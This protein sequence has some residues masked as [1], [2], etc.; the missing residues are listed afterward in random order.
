MEINFCSACGKLVG[1]GVHTCSPQSAIRAVT[2]LQAE[3]AE[4]KA[5][6]EGHK[7]SEDSH[8]ALVREIDEIISG[9]DGM[10]QQA[11]LCDLIGP[12]RNL[13]AENERLKGKQEP[14]AWGGAEEWEKLAYE[15]CAEENGEECCNQ[16]IWEGYPPEPWGERWLKYEDEAKRMIALVR[17]HTTP[18]DLAAKVAE[19]ESEFTAYKRATDLAYK[20]S[21]QESRDH[22]S[23]LIEQVKAAR[24]IVSD[25][26]TDLE[27]GFV[28]CERC[29]DQEDTATLDVVP[30]LRDCLAKLQGASNG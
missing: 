26:L 15:L 16:L 17:K 19:L 24:S 13:V 30:L 1:T 27:N 29:G 11:S 3:N 22:I 8:K 5:K 7:K 21:E 9:K 18:P 14:V 2:Q 28:R 10:A 23:E 4:L 12:I 20:G 25:C 6:I